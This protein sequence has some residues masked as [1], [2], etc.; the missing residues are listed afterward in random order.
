LGTDTA[1]KD[2]VADFLIRRWHG[3]GGPLRA[4][5]P[6][7]SNAFRPRPRQNGAPTSEGASRPSA[8][9]RF[10][11]TRGDGLSV[12]IRRRTLNFYMRFIQFALRLISA[13]SRHHDVFGRTVMF[14][15]ARAQ[16]AMKS[17]P[18]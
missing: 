14:R 16:L 6:R 8:G 5:A 12:M 13:L 17:S 2:C 18:F 4:R 9:V 7:A 15:A 1:G 3:A 11:P 10:V